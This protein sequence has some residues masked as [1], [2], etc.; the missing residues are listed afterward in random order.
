M[1]PY[2]LSLVREFIG[3]NLNGSL[4]LSRIAGIAGLSPYHFA[5]CFKAATGMAPHHY[6]KVRRVELARLKLEGSAAALSEI[7][8]S[9]GFSS[10]QHMSDAFRAHF[11][12][13]PG[14]YRRQLKASRL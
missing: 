13:A 8:F 3:N 6:V 12:M 5:R 11:G 2:R 9:C 7:A 10:Q 1:S 4:P 14:S